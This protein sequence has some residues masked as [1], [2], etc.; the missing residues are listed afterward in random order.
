MGDVQPRGR[1]DRAAI[2]DGDEPAAVDLTDGLGQAARPAALHLPH[3][4]RVVGVARRGGG[5]RLLQQ[6]QRRRNLRVAEAVVGG[7]LRDAQRRQNQR[8]LRVQSNKCGTM[9]IVSSQGY[10]V[11]KVETTRVANHQPLL[12]TGKSGQA[13]RIAASSAKFSRTHAVHVCCQCRL[14][15]KS[16]HFWSPM[17][18]MQPVTRGSPAG[19]VR[20]RRPDGL[21]HEVCG[22]AP[23]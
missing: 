20:A 8:Q 6:L 15:T 22:R 14:W 18:P 21:V 10:R 16:K 5:R 4:L 1:G 9:A 23:G 11:L 19:A 17:V 2:T 13:A 12:L 7:H 3:V